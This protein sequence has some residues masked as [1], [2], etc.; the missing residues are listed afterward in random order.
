MSD[1]PKTPAKI[2]AIPGMAILGCFAVGVLGI[3]HA[4]N[5]TQAGLSLLASA[6]AFSVVVFVSFRN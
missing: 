1:D 2:S 4:F 3:V 5:S 6:V